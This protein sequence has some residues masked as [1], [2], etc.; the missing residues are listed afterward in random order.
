MTPWGSLRDTAQCGNS[1]WMIILN[2]D[3]AVRPFGRR[4]SA[5]SVDA[6]AITDFDII[7]LCR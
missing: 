6:T 7:V 1:C 3:Y 2:A 5:T 4:D